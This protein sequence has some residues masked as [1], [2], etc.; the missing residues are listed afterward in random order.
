MPDISLDEIETVTRTA[1]ER[2]GARAWIAADVARAVRKAE[3][4]GNRICGLY[5]LES[6]C[7]Q[8]ES[9]RVDGTVDPVVSR[10]RPGSVVVD[11]KLGF[12]QPAFSRALPDAP[13]CGP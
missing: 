9:G 7:Q 4:V 12:A 11:A 5:Y 13:L 1:L 3:A 8:L 10:P 2:H 6:Y